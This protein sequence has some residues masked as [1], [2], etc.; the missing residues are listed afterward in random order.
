MYGV[1][2]TTKP[3]PSGSPDNENDNDNNNGNGNGN[4]NSTSGNNSGSGNNGSSSGSKAWI[5]GAVVGPILGL[6]L[7][8][9]ALWFLRRRK[10]AAASSGSDIQEADSATKINPYLQSPA[11]AYAPVP[12]HS[13]GEG[14]RPSE[15]GGGHDHQ[16]LEMEDQSAA[17]YAQRGSAGRGS[18][19]HEMG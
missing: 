7:I 8:G 16:M 4:G 1:L 5:A 12:P 19:V 9:A 14:A 6:A 3:S 18:T 2:G 13:P 15:L 17:K 11:S 10:N